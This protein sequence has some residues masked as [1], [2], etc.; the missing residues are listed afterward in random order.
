MKGY[1]GITIALIGFLLFSLA[2]VNHFVGNFFGLKI[3]F[4]LNIITIILF[5]I[6]GILIFLGIIFSL[7]KSNNIKRNFR[8]EFTKKRVR[9]Y[10]IFFVIFLLLNIFLYFMQIINFKIFI[11]ILVTLLIS[12]IFFYIIFPNKR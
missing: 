1:N 12:I 6:G 8:I 4:V 7:I 2:L 9:F 5:F 10:W 3:L 11:R